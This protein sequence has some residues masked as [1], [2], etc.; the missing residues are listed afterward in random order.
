MLHIENISKTFFPGTINEKR[1]LQHLS[2]HLKPGDFVTV[3]GGNG[4]GKS[5][6]LNAV[7]GV[8]PIDSGKIIIAGGD[9]HAINF[10][11]TFGIMT[12]ER[13]KTI[14][15]LIDVLKNNKFELYLG[16]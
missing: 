4:A 10:D 14:D 13:I 5:T 9:K 8:F 16:E 7:A 1:A 12:K 11:K 3:I 2:L 15:Q 6:M